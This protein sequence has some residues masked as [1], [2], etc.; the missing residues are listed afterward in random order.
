MLEDYGISPCWEQFSM[1]IF[2]GTNVVSV[3]I[4]GDPETRVVDG[5]EYYLGVPV[6]L[7]EA[8]SKFGNPDLAHITDGGIPEAPQISVILLWDSIKMRIDLLEIDG[9]SYTVDNTTQIQT[10]IY[11]DVGPHSRLAENPSSQPWRGYGTYEPD[12]DE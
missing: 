8:I 4:G 7:E 3:A 2:C 12:L 9:V 6:T 10:V 11:W 5:S 1:S